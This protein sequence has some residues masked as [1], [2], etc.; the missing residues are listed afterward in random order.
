V[1]GDRQDAEWDCCRNWAIPQWTHTSLDVTWT[2]YLPV[3]SYH[4]HL[5]P[6]HHHHQIAIEG[7]GHLLIYSTLK[8][9]WSIDM[10]ARQIAKLCFARESP[11]HSFCHQTCLSVLLSTVSLQLLA[12]MFGVEMKI[13]Q[14]CCNI[15]P[16]WSIQCCGW[17]VPGFFKS[18]CDCSWFL[19][20]S[21]F[22]RE[23][24]IRHDC[25]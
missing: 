12:L 3:E 16:G 18:R 23:T 24:H 2:G 25:G 10:F 1:N 20:S 21:G 13:W 22:W 17:A 8:Q 5:P 4:S 14:Q 7:L 6:P 11:G 19:I 15:S 9:H